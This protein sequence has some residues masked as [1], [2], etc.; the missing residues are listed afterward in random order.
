[1]GTDDLEGRVDF[2]LAFAVVH[3]LPDAGRFFAEARR[4]TK[5]GGRLLLS[6]PRMHVSEAAFAVTL[7]LARGA[8]FEVHDRP[9]IPMT[10]SA[11]VTAR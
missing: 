1:M 6:E 7:E 2:V 3:E 10:R 9:A 4:A 8:G 11:V 5:P